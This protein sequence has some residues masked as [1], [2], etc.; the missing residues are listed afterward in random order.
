MSI[1]V[2]ATG[3]GAGKT[4][5]FL[6]LA[7]ALQEEGLAICPF[8]TGPDFL[9]PMHLA[10]VCVNDCYN[11]DTWMSSTDHVREMVGRSAGLALIEGVMGYYDGGGSSGTRG[12]AAELAEVLNASVILVAPAS[13]M[14]ASFAALVSGFCN[15]SQAG[16]RIKAVVANGCNSKRHKVVLE[17]SLEA[18][19]L[20]PLVGAVPKFGL[21]CLKSRHLGLVPEQEQ[22][23]GKKIMHFSACGRD[24]FDLEKIKKMA[25]NGPGKSNAKISEGSKK[26][27]RIAVARDAAF[28]FYYQANLDIL[29]ACGARI[30]QFS[31]LGDRNLPADIAALYLGG[32]YP[33]HFGRELEKNIGIKA[34]IAGFVRDGGH[35][36]A[37]CGGMIYL[38]ETLKDTRDKKYEMCGILPLLSSM[39]STRRSLGYVEVEFRRDCILG[40][41][42]HILRGHE[43]HYSDVS[44]TADIP[45]DIYRVRNSQKQNLDTSGYVQG[46]ILASYAHLYFG[47][48]KKTAEHILSY[49]QGNDL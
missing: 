26:G 6:A 40:N 4:S 25:G 16:K 21:P 30:I 7:A 41:K 12:S 19:G 31:P 14:S 43:F 27:P 10:S 42:G 8:K 29:E 15:F 38:G 47:H 35:V 9:D 45:R 18:A 22:G 32:G 11:L 20:P 24:F 44:L 39:R 46:N 3:S 17:K 37:E 1:I 33:E 13:G 36:Y 28:N 48:S 2:S 34:D 5:V 23:T 49:I